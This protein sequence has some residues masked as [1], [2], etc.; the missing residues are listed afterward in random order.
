MTVGMIANG[1]L[2]E[3]VDEPSWML[4][5]SDRSLPPLWQHLGGLMAM[6]L[7][8]AVAGA[9]IVAFWK[10]ATGPEKRSVWLRRLF[11]QNPVRGASLFATLA[12]L[13]VGYTA[14]LFLV[15]PADAQPRFLSYSRIELIW[16]TSRTLV[17]E[18][19]VPAILLVW[20]GN[21][22]LAGGKSA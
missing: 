16:L 5:P 19:L 21:R 2:R 18:F 6:F 15:Q 17:M 11:Q 3:F 22:Y 12:V 20:V 13:S 14:Y 8:L 4:M 9:A 1:M 7:P 10:G